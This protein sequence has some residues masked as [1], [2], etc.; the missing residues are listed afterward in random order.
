MDECCIIQEGFETPF[1][2]LFQAYRKWT[3]NDPTRLGRHQLNEELRKQFK[4]IENQGK[5]RPVL[6]LGL[7]VVGQEDGM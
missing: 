5:H 6:F 2:A 7:S 4:V 1:M 3:K